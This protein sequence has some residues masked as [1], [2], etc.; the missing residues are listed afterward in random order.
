MTM[1]KQIKICSTCRFGVKNYTSV[2]GNIPWCCEK[3][4]HCKP[5]SL[6]SDYMP[7]KGSDVLHQNTKEANTPPTNG[8]YIRTMDNKELSEW[9]CSIMTSECCDRTCP[10]REFC[11]FGHKGLL[12]WLQATYKEEI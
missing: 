11:E 7:K 3:H 10:G 1:E 12:D 2:I 8:D 5:G 9:L 6:A 4:W